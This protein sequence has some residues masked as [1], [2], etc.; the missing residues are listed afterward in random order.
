M[1]VLQLLGY[2]IWL[3][4]QVITAATE[5]IADNLRVRPRQAPVL[6]EVP[7]RVDRDAEIAGLA[8]SITMTPG[9]LVCGIRDAGGGARSLLVHCVFGA[10]VPALAGS[11]HEMEERMSPRVRG[12]R[13]PPVAVIDDYDPDV[14]PDPRAVTGTQ[15][16][17]A[18]PR[19]AEP[20][21]GEEPR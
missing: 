20:A 15:H 16:E 21:A 3:V 18:E 17:V 2:A 19:P 6:L 7:L 4:G 9:T 12:L 14:H 8:A 5:V 10:D 1:R 11:F 13:R